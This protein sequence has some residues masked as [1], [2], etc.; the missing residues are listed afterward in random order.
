MSRNLLLALLAIALWLTWDSFYVIQEGE[1]AIVTRF[2][3]YKTSR[4]K[5]GPYFKVPMADDVNRMQ[6]RVLGSDTPP[7]EYLTLDKKKL[8]ADPI[9]RWRIVNPIKFYKTVRSE[10]GAKAR[11]DDIVNSELRGEIA[12]HEFGA[13]IGSRRQP[14][15][16]K[17]AQQARNKVKDF[18]IELVDVQIKR[19]DLPREVQDSVFQRMRAERDRIAKRYRSEGEEEAQKIRAQTDKEKSILLAKAYEHAQELIGEGDAKGVS[20]YAEAY[21]K[22]AEFYSLIR[23]LDAYESA[24][25]EKTHVVLSTDSDLLK[26]L[27]TPKR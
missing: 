3:E 7:A 5:P 24:I 8:V 19:A 14:L 9:S 26:Y 20:I 12:S 13:I 25:D 15:M 22:D 23:S 4:L 1:L 18:G 16:D 2:G 10:S 27:A 6:K 21:G 17:V 11:I